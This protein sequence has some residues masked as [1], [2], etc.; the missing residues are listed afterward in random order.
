MGLA[1]L[2]LAA[3]FSELGSTWMAWA[4]LLLI[5]FIWPQIAFLVARRSADPYLAERRNLIIDS[6]IAA[7]CLPIL[8]FNLLPSAVL[9]SVTAADKVN[10]GVRRLWL[11]SIPGMILAPILIGT[12]TGFKVDLHSSTFVV[13]CCLP[14]LII[15]VFAVSINSNRLVRRLQTQNLKLEALSRIDVMTGLFDRTHW[16]KKAEAI[17]ARRSPTEPCVL[18]ILDIDQFKTINDRYGHAV[19]D[20]VLKAIAQVVRDNLLIGSHAGRWGGDEFVIVMPLNA[21]Q[22]LIVAESI[23]V[24]VGELEFPSASSLRCTLSIGLAEAPA[25]TRDLRN[26]LELADRALYRAKRGGR[27]RANTSSSDMILGSG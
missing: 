11:H 15:H 3:V 20:D 14:L 17:L 8:H 9:I 22:T 25:E 10:S 24:T 21:S 26:W 4:W 13:I 5:C 6:A 27:N 18:M 2:P 7:A 23:R 12:L 19:G 1:S 16:E